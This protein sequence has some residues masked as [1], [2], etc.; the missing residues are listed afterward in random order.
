MKAQKTEIML[1]LIPNYKTHPL[2][3]YQLYKD[4]KRLSQNEQDREYIDDQEY[5]QHTQT[6]ALFFFSVA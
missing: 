1:Y 3:M 6:D 2:N 5:Q 4:Y